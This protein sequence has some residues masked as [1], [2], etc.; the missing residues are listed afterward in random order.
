MGTITFNPDTLGQHPAPL[1]DMVWIPGGTFHGLGRPLSGGSP[2]PSGERF[3]LLDRPYQVT[4]AAF[5]RFVKATGYVTL[6]ERV[7]EAAAYPGANVAMLVP[8]S[9]VFTQPSARIALTTTTP[10]G[11]GCRGPTGGTRRDPGARSTGG[12]GTRSCMSPG[13]M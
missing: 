13:R 8:G 12:S 9:V 3:R 5:R 11:T 1:K 4:N 2:G 10:G 6:A 7:P